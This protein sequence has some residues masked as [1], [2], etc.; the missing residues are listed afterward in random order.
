MN[1]RESYVYAYLRPEGEEPCYIG[2]GKGERWLHKTKAGGRNPHFVRLVAKARALGKELLRVKLLEGLTDL[3]ACQLESDLIRL[4][5]REAYGG[6]LVNLT[7][8]GDGPTGY[9]YTEEQ[10]RAHGAK[11]PKTLTPEWRAAI[12]AGMKASAKVKANAVK[13]GRASKGRKKS[14][15]WWSTPEGRANHMTPEARA[16]ISISVKLAHAENRLPKITPEQREKMVAGIR[17]AHAERPEI[18]AKISATVKAKGI[19]PPMRAAR[20]L[21]S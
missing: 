11:R 12:S 10:R 13:A 1:E 15:G 20:S 8:G 7:D 18:A 16:R 2:K 17:R 21:E 3:E 19:K 9:R 14:S 4:I 5:G 6:P